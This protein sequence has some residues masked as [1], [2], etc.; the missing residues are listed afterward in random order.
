MITPIGRLGEM[1]TTL[2]PKV[3]VHMIYRYINT[4]GSS[5]IKEKQHNLS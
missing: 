4:Q 2:L 1:S 3:L 5:C